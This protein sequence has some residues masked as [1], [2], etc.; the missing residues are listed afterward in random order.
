MAGA[1][2]EV[3]IRELEQAQAVR[4]ERELHR[5]R[6]IDEIHDA[7]LGEGEDPGLVVRVDRIEQ[8]HSTFEK[9]MGGVV[10]VA[11][12]IAAVFGIKWSS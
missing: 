12:A 4:D 11:T 6:K 5:D 2:H 3:R 10:A 1:N 8:R 7:L 9:L